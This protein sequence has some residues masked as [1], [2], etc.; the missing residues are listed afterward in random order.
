MKRHAHAG[1]SYALSAFF[2]GTGVVL[3]LVVGAIT[4][5]ALIAPNTQTW[6]VWT[7]TALALL[8][9]LAITLWVTGAVLAARVHRARRDRV[10]TFLTREERYRVLEATA[11][12]EAATSGEIRVHLAE[13]SHGDPTRAAAQAFERLGMTRTEE[14]NGILLFVSVRDRHVAVIGDRGIHERVPDTFWAQVVLA[15]E[16]AFAEG[17]FA[18]G[19]V[20]GIAMAGAQLAEHF[21]HRAGDRN[22]LPDTISDDT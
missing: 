7:T 9:L 15:V 11:R 20:N 1:R 6:T 12:F 3:A 14:R 19:L 22:E 4:L 2:A 8:G 16:A 10:H 18:D 17:R 21:P 5:R 13:H